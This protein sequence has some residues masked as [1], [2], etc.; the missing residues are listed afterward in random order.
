[1]Y[2]VYSLPYAAQAYYLLGDYETTL[3][4]LE[5]FE[6]ANL[7]TGDF[8][9]RWG[10][11]GR[12]RLLRGAAYERLGRL[13]EARAEYRQVM[14]QWKAADPEIQPFLNQARRG[15]ARVG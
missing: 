11:L 10:M 7:F 13:P 1:M 6:P 15:L 9:S 4:V 2:K 14:A 8:D 5:G 12:V 3:R